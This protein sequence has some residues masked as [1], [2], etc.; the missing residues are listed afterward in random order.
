MATWRLFYGFDESDGPTPHSLAAY[1]PKG[2]CHAA[3]RIIRG[4]L[5]FDRLW[6]VWLVGG[7]VYSFFWL[8]PFLSLT[9]FSPSVDRFGAGRLRASSSMRRLSFPGLIVLADGVLDILSS[10]STFGFGTGS[11]CLLGCC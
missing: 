6:G 2:M 5:L 3:A 4:Y 1:W 11:L 8:D 9:L 7:Q 10:G